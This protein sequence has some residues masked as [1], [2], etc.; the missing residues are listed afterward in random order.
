MLWQLK[1]ESLQK[2]Q[3]QQ[4]YNSYFKKRQILMID[5]HVVKYLT[6]PTSETIK[7]TK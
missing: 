1:F 7:Q 5:G 3:Q 6:V 2:Q 4:Y